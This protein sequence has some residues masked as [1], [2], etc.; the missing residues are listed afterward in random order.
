MN[1]S[2]FEDALRSARETAFVIGVPTRSLAPCADTQSLF[3]RV[4]WLAGDSGSWN[5]LVTPLVDARLH[6][7]VRADRVS[8]TIDW[9]G[10]LHFG[11]PRVP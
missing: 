3:A 6:A 10:A 11:A 2:D 7:I 4:P 8:A 5:G 1:A 9:S